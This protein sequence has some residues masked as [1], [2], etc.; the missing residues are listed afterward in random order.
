MGFNIGTTSAPN[1]F[2]LTFK[3]AL[4]DGT[5]MLVGNPANFGSSGYLSLGKTYN[6]MLDY[7][8]QQSDTKFLARPRIITMNNETAEI[9][10]T[11]D[12][13]VNTKTETT[14]PEGGGPS[15]Q[16]VTYDRATSL[17]LTPEGIGVFLRVTP[18]INMET[19]EVTLVVNPKTSSTTQSSQI[20]TE[21]QVALD[22]EVRSAKSIVK[23]KDGE[24]VVLGGLIHKEKIETVKKLPILSDIP[25]A[26]ALFRHKYVEKNQDRELLV[27]ITTH[28]LKEQKSRFALNTR[29]GSGYAQQ[30]DQRSAQRSD[31]DSY[32]NVFDR[33]RTR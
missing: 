3:G 28:I 13:I 15:T 26:G 29:E 23:V 10:I 31:V 12:E 11:K 17:T 4:T 16:T 25:I 24:T 2:T 14:T 9:G 21:G 32:M 30:P 33:R 7:L 8:R 1:P 27:F 19:G 20:T 6:L 5:K 18:Q 22:P